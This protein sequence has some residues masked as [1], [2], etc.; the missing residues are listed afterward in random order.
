MP[1]PETPKVIDKGAIKAKKQM[2]ISQSSNTSQIDSQTAT[3]ITTMAQLPNFD[4]P[5]HTLPDPTNLLEKLEIEIENVNEFIG[6]GDVDLLAD[7]PLTRKV[8][9]LSNLGIRE[10]CA[11]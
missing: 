4:Q 11:S 8:P 5:T 3:P 10:P 6:D 7:D 2:Q 1:L 9:S